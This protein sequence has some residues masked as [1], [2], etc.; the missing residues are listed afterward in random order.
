[1]WYEVP[2]KKPSE[3]WEKNIGWC[4]VRLLDNVEWDY[5]MRRGE[6]IGGCGVRLLHDVGWDY[7]LGRDYCMMWG[8]IMAWCGVRLLG[9]VG[10]DYNLGLDYWMMWGEIIWWDYDDAFLNYIK[11]SNSNAEIYEQWCFLFIF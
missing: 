5:Y 9:D 11:L 3:K 10:W 2:N 1:M 8:E 4:G 7:N 6:F